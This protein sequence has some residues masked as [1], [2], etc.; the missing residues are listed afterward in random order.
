ML[1]PDT[2]SVAIDILRAPP[3]YRLDTAV[4]TTYSLDLEVLLALPLAVLAEADGG[5]E[6]LLSEP[7]HLLEALREATTRVQVFVDA[8]GMAIP[9]VPRNL[10]AALEPSI[11]PVKAPG[12]GA[13]H[14]K[15]WVV[16]F[17]SDL[18]GSV[19]NNNSH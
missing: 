1:A 15:V 11:H 10:Y 5:V 18:S 17:V 2:R 3:G 19:R 16:R 14:P 12:G 7:L 9:R 6:E 8:A 13:F 4:L